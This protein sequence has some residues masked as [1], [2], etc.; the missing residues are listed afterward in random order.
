MATIHSPSVRMWEY[1]NKVSGTEGCRSI[2][3][4]S[5]LEHGGARSQQPG[6]LTLSLPTQ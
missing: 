3:Q 2:R 4:Q 5:T 6:G 1:F